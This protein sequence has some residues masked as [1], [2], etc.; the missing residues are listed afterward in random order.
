MAQQNSPSPQLVTMG[1]VMVEMTPVEEGEPLRE[2]DLLLPLPSG[3]ATNFAVAAC[4]LGISVSLISRVG[5]DEWG[6]WLCARLA[7]LGIDVRYVAATPGQYST[8]SFCWMDRRGAKTFYFYRFPG[9]CDPLGALAP[10]EVR[11][12]WFEGAQCFDFSEATV[13]AEPLRSAAFEAA[14]LAR[15]AGCL[16]VYAVNYRAS[17][18]AGRE[19]ELV[20][21]QRQAIST[22]DVAIMN[23]EEAAIITGLDFQEAAAR[24]VSALGPSVVAVTAGSSGAWVCIRGEVTFV[25]AYQVEVRYDIGAGDAFH[26]GLV[27]ALL[28]GLDAHQAARL[29]A[30]AAAL[31][32]SRPPTLDQ[33]PTWDEAAAL[34]KV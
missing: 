16:V 3:A 17:G 4:R 25:P 27:A 21:T 12:E 5:A 9:Y 2:A 28:K 6:E 23:A 30:A 13:R 22:A 34:A 14:R 31:K 18:W 29:A 15:E 33:L 7:R 8:V 20:P 24:Q 26:A 1:S 19:T 11:K 32:I 10:A